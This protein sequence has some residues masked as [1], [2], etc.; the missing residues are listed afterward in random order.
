MT[1]LVI[2]S[3]LSV[4]L[5]AAADPVPKPVEGL[6]YMVGTWKGAGTVAMGKDKA[7][8]DAVWNCSRVSGKWGVLCSPKITGVPGM[9]VIDL[10]RSKDSKSMT[11]RS[12]N[13]VAGAS[14]A[15]FE[16]KMRKS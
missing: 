15:V 12:E 13:F 11:G 4:S 9:A 16:F 7:K 10:E 3:V 1:K 6:D 8:I 2:L 14:T 5:V